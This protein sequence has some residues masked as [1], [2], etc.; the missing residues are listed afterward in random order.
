MET[1]ANQKTDGVERLNHNSLYQPTSLWRKK[2]WFYSFSHCLFSGIVKWEER[3]VII[4]FYWFM[5]L[6]IHGSATDCEKTE[7]R[8]ETFTL[9]LVDKT[10]WH[11]VYNEGITIFGILRYYDML[12]TMWWM[13]KAK[14]KN[15]RRMSGMS[16]KVFYIFV[17][18][19]MK[20]NSQSLLMVWW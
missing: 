4:S 9:C 10:Q 19:A 7:T 16:T 15:K 5:L 20:R 8:R 3:K 11:A 6:H 14:Q 18:C 1:Y 12:K 17:V 13:W 2:C